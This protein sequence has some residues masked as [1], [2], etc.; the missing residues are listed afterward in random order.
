MPIQR[1][2]GECRQMHNPGFLGYH[3]QDEPIFLS[4]PFLCVE[5]LIRI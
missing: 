4:F 1:D 3:L 2:D 5:E